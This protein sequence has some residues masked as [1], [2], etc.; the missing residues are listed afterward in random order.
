[1]A[2]KVTIRASQAGDTV[3][4]AAVDIDQMF[5]V[6]PEKPEVMQGVEPSRVTAVGCPSCYSY[7]WYFDGNLVTGE[8]GSTYLT[9]E[10]GS[11]FVVGMTND[12]CST[13]SD[14]VVVA[15]TSDVSDISTQEVGVYPNPFSDQARI[16]FPNPDRESFTMRIYDLSG[17][18]VGSIDNIFE[19]EVLLNRG[20]LSDGYYI[21]E[22]RGSETYR[23]NLIL[24]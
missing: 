22:L 12:G 8:T 10:S 11:Y 7:Q 5:C 2:G 23:R 24:R 18:I 17:K 14:T 15:F 6:N 1:M 3:Y 16:T 19:S 13:S 9:S 20:Q 21:L 4:N